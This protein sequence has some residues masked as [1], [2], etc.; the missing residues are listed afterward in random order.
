[1]QLQCKMRTRQRGP[2]NAVPKRCTTRAVLVVAKVGFYL[3]LDEPEL[4]EGP[5]LTTITARGF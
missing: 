1:M 3:K 4:L 5:R 2:H